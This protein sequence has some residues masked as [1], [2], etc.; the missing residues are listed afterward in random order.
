MDN[1][2]VVFTVLGLAVTIITGAFG[3]I[4]KQM[5]DT[6]KT[7]REEMAEV[8]EYM[9]E[10]SKEGRDDRVAI[11]SELRNMERAAAGSYREVLDRIAK[12][13]TRDELREELRVFEQRIARAV[14][15]PPKPR[16]H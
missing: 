11:W 14:T 8:R 7:L 6:A 15:E 4:W 13:P 16:T 2:D 10:R 12:V 5:N 1:H 9:D 3:I